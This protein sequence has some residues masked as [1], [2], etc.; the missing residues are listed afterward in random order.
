MTEALAGGGRLAGRVAVV[1]GAGIPE[2]VGIGAASAILFAR[3]GAA[4]VVVERDVEAAAR[5]IQEIEGE[6]GTATAVTADVSREDDVRRAIDETLSRFGRLDVLQNTVGVVRPGGLADSTLDD[7]MTIYGINLGGA[8]LTCRAVL[9]HMRERGRGAI[10]NVSS[11]AST[12]TTGSLSLPYATS[13]AAL[14]QLTRIVAREGSDAGIRCNAVIP[15][16]LDTPAARRA[17]A[18][19]EAYRRSVAQRSADVPLARLG[20]ASE[21]AEACLFLASDA[22]SYITGAMLP[23]DGG[24]S[25]L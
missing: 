10:V 18:D 20:V 23:V 19:D 3:E 5:T 9:P 8:F 24:L 11:I 2:G 13:K 22:A 21:V 14:E 17:V 12:R 1:T 7:V 4:V 16:S 15:G 25:L 6:G